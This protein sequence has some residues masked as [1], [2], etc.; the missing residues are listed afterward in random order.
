MAL[1]VWENCFAIFGRTSGAEARRDGDGS[2]TLE[3]KGRLPSSMRRRLRI[4]AL[5][6]A[7]SIVIVT[8]TSLSYRSC[9][10]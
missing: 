3:G 6:L 4:M 10:C 9:K 8:G 2:P 7:D 1:G 5:G